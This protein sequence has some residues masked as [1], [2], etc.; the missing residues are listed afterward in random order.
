M[1]RQLPPTTVT[2]CIRHPGIGCEPRK[3]T[4]E[5]ALYRTAIFQS[6]LIPASQSYVGVC[7]CVCVCCSPLSNSHTVAIGVCPSLIHFLFKVTLLSSL[8]VLIGWAG[9]HLTSPTHHKVAVLL[10]LEEELNSLC[11]A[12]FVCLFFLLLFF[13]FWVVCHF[14]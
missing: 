14:F 1:V 11:M 6:C 7:V 4:T 3:I 5:I 13:C 8:E 9:C 12:V 2:C 10:S